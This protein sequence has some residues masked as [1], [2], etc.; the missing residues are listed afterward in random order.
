MSRKDKKDNYHTLFTQLSG[1]CA[2]Y[3]EYTMSSCHWQVQGR[4]APQSSRTGVH[5]FQVGEGMI[6]EVWVLGEVGQPGKVGK[7]AAVVT[8]RRRWSRPKT[9]V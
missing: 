5:E 4:D 7:M 6:L 1:V 2:S 8:T 9:A 3:N